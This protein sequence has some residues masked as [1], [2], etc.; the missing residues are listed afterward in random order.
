M[1]KLKAD[2]AASLS[3]YSSL[4]VCVYM[5]FIYLDGYMWNHICSFYF[6]F[7]YLF[8]KSVKK[9]FFLMWAILKIFIKFVTI[10]LLFYV[11]DFWWWSLWDLKLPDQGL[12]PHPCTGRQSLNHWT[13]NREVPVV[14]KCYLKYSSPC[15]SV[16]LGDNL[17]FNTYLPALF[18]I[19]CQSPMEID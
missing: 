13:T 2:L 10:L 8:F 11:L 1:W 9:V 15:T 17:H 4:T 6:L 16:C 19:I 12:N 5:C 3:L 14:F 18:F 7:M